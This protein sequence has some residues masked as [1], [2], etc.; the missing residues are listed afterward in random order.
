MEASLNFNKDDDTGLYNYEIDGVI[1]WSSGKDYVKYCN[2]FDNV[3]QKMFPVG[4]TLKNAF[5]RI[6]VIGG[7]DMQLMSST[8]LLRS[9]DCIIDLVDPLVHEYQKL[10]EDNK[11]NISYYVYSSQREPYVMPKF[12]TFHDKTI[13]DFLS[14]ELNKDLT[15]DLIIVDLVDELAVDEENIYSSQIWDRLRHGGIILG[16]GGTN[17]TKFLTE[18]N[19]LAYEDVSSLIVDKKYYKSW[20]DDCIVYGISKE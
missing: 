4:K 1:Q 9:N 2:Q 8:V 16:Y 3:I 6:L 12:T 14:D 13:Q 18:S 15:Y 20:N 17:M 5:K 11:D 10:L 19:F 7:G